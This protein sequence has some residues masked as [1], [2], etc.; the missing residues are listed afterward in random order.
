[1]TAC[2]SRYLHCRPRRSV[3]VACRVCA[4]EVQRSSDV[5]VR[6]AH[7]MK[8]WQTRGETTYAT[9]KALKKIPC[10]VNAVD[11]SESAG[12][13]PTRTVNKRLR[14]I[15]TTLG[16]DPSG[17]TEP[18]VEQHLGEQH[19]HAEQYSRLRDLQERQQVH[20]LVFRLYTRSGATS[21]HTVRT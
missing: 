16:T 2:S 14:D 9:K 1:M 4:L 5:K 17:T 11:I 13:E 19:H 21:G 10:V 7:P 15:R 12:Q 6:Q 3:S 8:A 18:V 20:A